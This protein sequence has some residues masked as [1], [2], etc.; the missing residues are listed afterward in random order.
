MENFIFCAVQ[1]GTLF[2]ETEKIFQVSIKFKVEFNT[3][4]PNNFPQT[5]N[6]DTGR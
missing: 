3:S 4:L 6:K 1:Y 2:Q 5:S